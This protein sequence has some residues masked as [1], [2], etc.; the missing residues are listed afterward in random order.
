LSILGGTTF[1]VRHRK[2]AFVRNTKQTGWLWKT[3]SEAKRIDIILDYYQ[4]FPKIIEGQQESL[5]YRIKNEREYLRQN[6][7]D[8]LGVRVQTSGSS[9]PTMRE[10]IENLTIKAAV[11]GDK[12]MDELLQDVDQ[13][14]TK[15]IFRELYILQKMREEYRLLNNQLLLLSS[16][17]K[18]VFKLFMEENRDFQELADVRVFRMLLPGE[19]FGRFAKR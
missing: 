12:D 15:E 16:S 6:R 14:E 11:Q 5:F 9:N 18:R 13:T 2:I 7:R 4:E 3:S 19:E 10:A 1:S 8:D 17:E